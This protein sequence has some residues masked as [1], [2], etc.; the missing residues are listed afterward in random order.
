MAFLVTLRDHSVDEIDDA[1]AFAHERAMTTFFRT[2]NARGAVDCWSEAVAAYRT[3][4]ILKIRRVATQEAE[5][6]EDPA[7][8]R[9]PVQRTWVQEERASTQASPTVAAAGGASMPRKSSTSSVAS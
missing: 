4:E 1:D 7:V 6:I 8:L 3:D 2:N 9:L 5:S